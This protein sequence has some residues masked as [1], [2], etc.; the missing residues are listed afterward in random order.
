MLF[1]PLTIKVQI[2]EDFYK[3]LQRCIQELTGYVY[4]YNNEYLIALWQH[5]HYPEDR[6]FRRD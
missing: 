2:L 1:C 6:A 3:E 4:T 5:S